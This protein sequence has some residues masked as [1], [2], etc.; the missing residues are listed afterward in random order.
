[1]DVMKMK[2]FLLTLKDKAKVWFNAIG[3]K[4]IQS[5]NELQAV[6]L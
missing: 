5:W 1:M 2:L 4:S 6:F 3:P